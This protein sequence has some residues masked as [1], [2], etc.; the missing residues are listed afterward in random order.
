MH[1]RNNGRNSELPFETE[2][3]VNHDTDDHQEQSRQTVGSEFFTDLRSHEFRA[4]QLSFRSFLMNDFHDFFAHLSRS[5]VAFQRKPDLSVAGCTEVHDLDFTARGFFQVHAQLLHRNG[6]RVVDFHHQ[7][8]GELNGES[9]TANDQEPNRNKERNKRNRVQYL[10]IL[11]E[12]NR[13]VDS[14]QFHG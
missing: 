14:K 4:A 7:T 13:F 3:Q 11:H 9:Q 5:L 2:G 12:R 10:G 1:I 6:I 8:A